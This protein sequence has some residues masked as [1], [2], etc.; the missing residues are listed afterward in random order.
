MIRLVFLIAS[1]FMM[2]FML[3]SPEEKEIE[4]V[5]NRL[6]DGMKKGDSAMVRSCFIKDPVLKTVVTRKDSSFLANESLEDFLEAVGTPHK[7][8]WNEKIK[9]IEIRIDKQL[10]S[11]WTPYEFYIDTT[12]SHCGVNL[13]QMFKDKN[14]WKIMSITDTRYR[15]GCGHD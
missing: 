2:S 4:K 5:V 15:K 3:Q 13:F 12:F 7:E 14:G 1:F 9:S 10:A 11:V 8:T 6:F